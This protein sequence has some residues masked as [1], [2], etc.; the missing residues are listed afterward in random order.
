MLNFRPENL[1][2]FSGRFYCTA[3]ILQNGY[4]V[5]ISITV[6]EFSLTCRTFRYIIVVEIRYWSD[7]HEI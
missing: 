3:T 2:R 5:Y 1:L 7:R 6:Y 4:N